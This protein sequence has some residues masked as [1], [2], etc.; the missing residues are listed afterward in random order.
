MFGKKKQSQ[1]EPP[2]VKETRNGSYLTKTE[3]FRLYV[4]RKTTSDDIIGTVL[5]TDAQFEILNVACNKEGVKF[6]KK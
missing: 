6:T 2:K 4:I 1:S 5:L 3:D